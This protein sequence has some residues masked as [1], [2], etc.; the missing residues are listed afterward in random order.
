MTKV[1]T[2]K[3]E[4]NKPSSLTQ[5]VYCN[6]VDVANGH[7]NVV[8]LD[9]IQLDLINSMYYMINRDVNKDKDL[10]SILD[11]DKGGS[12]EFELGLSE[13]SSMVGKYKKN[14]YS[15]IIKKIAA[16]Q[17]VKVVINALN[18]DKDMETIYTSVVTELTVVH[19]KGMKSIKAAFPNRLIRSYHNTQKYFKKHYLT[20]QFSLKSKYSKLLYEL[21]KDYEGLE[22]GINLELTS[23]LELLNVT[24]ESMKQP[25]RFK[26]HIMK[27][28]VEEINKL[29]DI[30]I[31]WEMTKK[32]KQEVYVNITSKK[33]NDSRLEELGLLEE[34][35]EKSPFYEKSK[36]KLDERKNRGQ[37]IYDDDAWIREDISRNEANYEAMIEIDSFMEDNNQNT[38][39][40]FYSKLAE[41]LEAEDPILI[42]DNYIIKELFGT[43]TY[44]KNAAE[45]QNLMVDCVEKFYS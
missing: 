37:K 38:K 4:I 28:S 35:V 6:K 3:Y 8:S 5:T 9:P 31:A 12:T 13:M 27:P 17:D 45:T 1:L 43:K 24:T 22:N 32:L 34:S 21:A 23:L 30:H 26:A 11:S 25:S 14:Q 41:M 33:Q 2:E 44:S 42:I 20:I 16:L 29:T 19:G 36:S 39:N 40:D 10:Q 18:K 15:T 7:L